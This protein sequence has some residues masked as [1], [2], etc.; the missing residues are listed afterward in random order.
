[1]FLP[2]QQSAGSRLVDN[3]SRIGLLTGVL[4]QPM[5]M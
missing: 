5:S 3:S 2:L 4:L 1:M